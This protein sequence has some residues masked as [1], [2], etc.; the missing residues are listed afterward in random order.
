MD[1][2]DCE[3]CDERH[4][5]THY[6]TNCE[7]AMC[8]TM[9]S[10]HTKQKIYKTHVVRADAE[11]FDYLKSK[12]EES[13]HELYKARSDLFLQYA[14]ASPPGND[15][16]PPAVERANEVF[17]LCI[18]AGAIIN[19]Q[20]DA[21]CKTQ[22]SLQKP[23]RP[24]HR[25]LFSTDRALKTMGFSTDLA[26]KTFKAGVL[27][28]KALPIWGNFGGR[29]GSYHY[30]VSM[31]ISPHDEV[32]VCDGRN[33][34]VQVFNPDGAPL[35]TWDVP[36][37]MSRD[38]Q[39]PV[40]IA[41][42]PWNEVYVIKRQPTH[43]YVFRTDGSFVR[44]W[45]YVLP[46]ESVG[47]PESV[48]IS[49]SST[50][51]V[52]VLHQRVRVFKPDGTF[53]RS[54]EVDEEPQAMCVAFGDVYV[55]SKTACYVYDLNGNPLARWDGLLEARRIAVSPQGRVFVAE[56]NGV[57]MFEHGRAV[58][59]CIDSKNPLAVAIGPDRLYVCRSDTH[60]IETISL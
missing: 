11:L 36:K 23:G 45:N 37:A 20:Y 44:T 33:Y 16:S 3:I 40:G 38:S 52:F 18:E 27:Q 19:G 51:E 8:T 56:E 9:A 24:S 46:M 21:L 29:L 1:S 41:V 42:A 47:A 39:Y 43:V 60:T 59:T 55:V 28:L 12:L 17:R 50:G 32:Y 13:L 49:T 58:R 4:E 5:G 15:N 48:G 14:D 25:D 7:V 2:N 30:P 54:W 35:R 22:R 53:A 57:R 10:I 26:L 34:R 6:C 31:A